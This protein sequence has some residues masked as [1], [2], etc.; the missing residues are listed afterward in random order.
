VVRPTD[1]RAA[2]RRSAIF[3]SIGSQDENHGKYAG[4]L[5]QR[6]GTPHARG[7]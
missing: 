3:H 1:F 6:A 5:G 7:R 2:F 4:F